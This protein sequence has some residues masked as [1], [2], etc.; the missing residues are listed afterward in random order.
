MVRV[1]PWR[2]RPRRS[3]LGPVPEMLSPIER[4]YAMPALTL[5]GRLICA[6]GAAYAIDGR[7]KVLVP[8]PKDL[9]LEGVGFLHDPVVALAG[10]DSIDGCLIGPTTQ[11]IILAFRG[12]MPFDINQPP[13]VHD[14]IGDFHA[15]PIQI[16]GFPGCV[17]A[18]FGGAFT[19]LWPR[20][21][22]ALRALI[23]AA[24]KDCPILVTGHSK[25]GAMAALAAWKIKQTPDLPP[26]KV[27]TFAA[28]KPADADFQTA[29]QAAGIDHV[30]Y[31]Y[32][33]DIVPH[34]PLSDQGFFEVLRKFPL[35][36]LDWF[37]DLLVEVERFDYRPVGT[38][39]YIKAD[40]E[41][42]NDSDQ[43]RR[44]RDQTLAFQ[45]LSGHF[46]QIAA[47]H[48]IGCGSGYMRAVAPSGVC[49]SVIA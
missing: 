49:P 16:D 8:D 45:V 22:L 1:D 30:R 42:V 5:E 48:S 47:N 13:S 35:D 34:L 20:I 19:A 37:R 12:T 2:G 27:V 44:Q 11:G 18:G 31:E 40:G 17:H 41:I 39:R 21:D 14:W 24:P 9:Y 7:M 25:G 10:D 15:E 23:P 4:R 6:S 36:A 46:A 33:I 32:N 26:P 3:A 38:L 28:A 43:L 29:Y